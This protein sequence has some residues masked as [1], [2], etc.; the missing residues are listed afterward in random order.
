MPLIPQSGLGQPPRDL[1]LGEVRGDEQQTWGSGPHAPPLSHYLGT[2]LLGEGA[3]LPCRPA[4]HRQVAPAL[5]LM[6]QPAGTE[7]SR[8]AG[9]TAHLAGR[10]QRHPAAPNRHAPRQPAGTESPRR[11]GDAAHAAG[12]R[13]RQAPG[14]AG[15]TGPRP[16]PPAA[17]P[18]QRTRQ[19]QA[20]EPKPRLPARKPR[21]ATLSQQPLHT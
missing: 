3:P 5:H 8:R 10:Q 13:R 17:V 20:G 6:R 14:P 4:R 7:S 2:A 19:A 9:D 11:A 12:L 21:A 15:R 16:P 1:G 18:P